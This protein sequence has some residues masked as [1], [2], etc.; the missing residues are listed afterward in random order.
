[1]YSQQGADEFDEIVLTSYF[2][3]RKRRRG[4]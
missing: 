4:D 1:M 3:L 2:V